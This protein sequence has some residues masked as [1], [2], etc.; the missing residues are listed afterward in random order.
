MHREVLTML[1]LM[2]LVSGIQVLEPTEKEIGEGS[3]VYLGEIGPGQT[4]QVTIEPRVTTGGILGKGGDYDLATVTKLP[5]EWKFEKSKLHGKPLQ[6]TITA[7]K[8]APEG[9]Y[10]VDITV[11]DEFNGEELGNVTFKGRVD[12]T[13][14][15]LDVEIAPKNVKVGPG[16]PA[17]FEITIHNKGTTSDVFEISSVGMK[18][19][20]FTKTVFVSGKSSKTIPY[21]MTAYEEEEYEAKVTVASM[22]SDIIQHTEDVTVVV[23][24]DVMGDYKA[25]NNGV[26]LFPLFEAP[27]Y[28]LA[29]L[30]SN[31]F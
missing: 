11:I 22:A 13:W 8:Y 17:K 16:Q 2:T 6:V 30:I 19:W 18:R 29:G 23:S 26:L 24:S 9:N 1:V 28:A 3:E 31:L 21:E 5:D 15:V 10:T 12:I 20:E 27:I 7:D 14:D 4:I 25:T